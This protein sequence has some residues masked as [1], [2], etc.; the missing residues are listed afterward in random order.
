MI[1][2]HFWAW[3]IKFPSHY[4]F[5]EWTWSFCCVIFRQHYVHQGDGRQPL[6]GAV[7]KRAA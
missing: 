4:V 6:W 7:W 3:Y 5:L 1:Q 2:S